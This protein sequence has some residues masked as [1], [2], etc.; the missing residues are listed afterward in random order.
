MVPFTV[1]LTIEPGPVEPG[2]VRDGFGES[3]VIVSPIDK[4]PMSRAADLRWG[5]ERLA[6]GTTVAT[7][8]DTFWNGRSVS[9]PDALD[10]GRVLSRRLLAHPAL[11][12]RW[13]AIRAWRGGRPLRLE[14]VLPPARTSAI[15][16]VPF[17]L[18]ADEDGFWFYGGQ[19]FARAVH[20][21]P[22]AEASED[23]AQRAPA[24]RLGQSSRHR[25]AR[26]RPRVRGPRGTP[27]ARGQQSWLRRPDHPA[28]GRA[29]GAPGFARGSPTGRDRFDRR[30]RLAERWETRPGGAGPFV[31]HGAGVHG[32]CRVASRRGAGCAAV[33]L[34]RGPPSRGPGLDR[35]KTPAPGGRRSVGRPRSARR[36][37]GELDPSRRQVDLRRADGRGRQRPRARGHVRSP[38]RSR[39]R[40]RVGY[41]RVPRAGRGTAAA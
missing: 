5:S 1:E 16:A 35:R 30:S 26:R 40:S 15:G 37:A 27:D 28:A 2:G 8:L 13:R 23:P 29:R 19:F 20:R 41:P 9:H 12:E 39:G 22:G 7:F 10:F 25:S 4:A 18:L 32:R 31:P 11:R 14:L 21:R 6:T 3:N 34:P 38:G 17:E 33:D 24:G 36:G